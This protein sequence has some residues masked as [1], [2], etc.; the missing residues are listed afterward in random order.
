MGDPATALRTIAELGRTALGELD[1]LVV[2]LRDPAAP[3]SVSAPPRL[4]DIDELLAE[5]LRRQ[6]VTVSVG[7]DADL[8]L[9]DTDVLTVY[10]IAQEALT[11]VARHARARH[12]WVEL[13]RRAGELRLRVSD[14]GV[15]VTGSAAPRLR[16]AGHRGAGD[17]ARRGVGARGASGWRDDGQCRAAGSPMTRVAVVDDQQLVRE[18][19]ALILGGQPDLEVV[20]Q[21]EDGHAVPRRRARR[22]A[23][24]R[25]P[26]RHP[27]AGP[28]RAGRHPGPDGGAA[29]AGRDRGDHVRGRRLRARRHRGRCA[30]VPAQAVQRTPARRRGP[31]GRRRRVDPV[32]RG[33][34][35]GAG[36]GAGLGA[37]HGRRPHG[38]R[39]DGPRAGGAGA[40]RSRASTTP[41]SPAGS[42]CP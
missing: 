20:L 38:V 13:R 8:G 6:G 42:T 41:R 24:R 29:R 32:R 23:D 21:A 10:R 34:R 30:R 4:L 19:F 33:H 27:D 40:R 12:V 15:G 7:L 1:G 14:D 22:P 39:P 35:G 11:N 31:D 25:R 16:A 5:P 17:G 2:H 37:G 28:G 26:G 3:L 9:D 36:P 18:G